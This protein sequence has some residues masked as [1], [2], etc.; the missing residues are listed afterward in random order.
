[1]AKI[2][3]SSVC[4]TAVLFIL[5]LVVIEIP[6]IEGQTCKHFEGEC[7]VTPC[8][9][10]KCDECCKAAFGKQKCGVCEQEGD[11]LHCHCRR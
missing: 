9:A 5:L 2:L 10:A 4:F 1:M 7:P 3:N 11:A 6:K 8:E